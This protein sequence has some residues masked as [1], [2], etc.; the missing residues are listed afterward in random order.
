VVVNHKRVARIMREERLIAKAAKLYRRK[1]LPTNPCVT[2][3]NLR[4]NIPPASAQA[5]DVIY[6]EVHCE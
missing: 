3:E 5:G 1:A 4:N 2:V 6:L